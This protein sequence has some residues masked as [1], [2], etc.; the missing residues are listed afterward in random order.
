M[1]AVT[2]RWIKPKILLALTRASTQ[3][4]I[5]DRLCQKSGRG[6]YAYPDGK[7]MI[8][9]DVTLLIEAARRKA[10]LRKPS[11]KPKSWHAS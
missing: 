7:R 3:V 2:T 4:D 11:P 8:D 6:W 5:A 10:S 1:A 9:P